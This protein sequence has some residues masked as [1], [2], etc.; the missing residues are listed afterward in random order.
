MKHSKVYPFIQME[1]QIFSIVE[2]SELII[3]FYKIL[4]VKNSD[5]K[6]INIISER[7]MKFPTVDVYEINAI[8]ILAENILNYNI[9]DII[10]VDKVSNPDINYKR[11]ERGGIHIGIETKNKSD[12]LISLT[13]SFYKK[14]CAIGSIVTNEICF[15]TFEKAKDFLEAANSVF[16]VDYSAIRILEPSLNELVFE[17]KAP[18]GWITYFSN[19]YEV[20][21]PNDLNDVE[22]EY[23]E[24]GKYLI[25]TKENI[26]TDLDK[27][28][29]NKNKLIELMK[30]VDV[31]SPTYSRNYTPPMQH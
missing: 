20:S 5:F 13:F 25:L 31:K 12:T 23:T 24:K 10:K 11:T 27:L 6:R 19:G 17:Y 4:T 21:I 28:E 16:C 15:D 14:R 3:S 18:L 9:G 22:Y 8:Q 26:S 1:S 29:L 2:I 7:K 30:Q